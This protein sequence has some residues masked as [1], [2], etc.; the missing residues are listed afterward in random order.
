MTKAVARDHFENALQSVRAAQIL[1]D[2]EPARL[3]ELAMLEIS[4][5]LRSLDPSSSTRLIEPE[6][7]AGE[8]IPGEGVYNRF[9]A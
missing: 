4:E 6:Y 1:A 2:G 5:G 8:M 9:E 3:L 7:S